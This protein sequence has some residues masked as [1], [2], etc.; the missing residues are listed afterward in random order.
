MKDWV[1]LVIAI[2]AAIIIDAILLIILVVVSKIKNA[3]INKKMSEDPIFLKQ[4]EEAKKEVEE[5]Y[6]RSRADHRSSS[7]GENFDGE[8]SRIREPSRDSIHGKESNSHEGRS[9]VSPQPPR[10]PKRDNRA[11]ELHRPT[12]L[13][14]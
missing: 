9:K 13:R 2:I 7:R 6:A 4:V 3:R 10:K 5:A 1:I 12:T 14:S 8:Q 11:V